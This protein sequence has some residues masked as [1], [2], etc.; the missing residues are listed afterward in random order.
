MYTMIFFSIVKFVFV[1]YPEFMHV[2]EGAPGPA[3]C[4]TDHP[5][6]SVY[7]TVCQLSAIHVYNMCGVFCFNFF[8]PFPLNYSDSV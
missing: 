7:D 3:S 8:V 1:N 2:C 5:S 6:A 4:G